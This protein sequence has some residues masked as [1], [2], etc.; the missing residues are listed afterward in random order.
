M[1]SRPSAGFYCAGAHSS[2]K[3]RATADRG[4]KANG[5]AA[6]ASVEVAALSNDEPH[7]LTHTCSE[8]ACS[9]AYEWCADEELATVHT[10]LGI[11]DGKDR[12]AS[13]KSKNHA[14]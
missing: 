11:S 4:P 2:R 12:H 7:A 5:D 8:R 3:P 14:R 6:G 9:A 1:K 13:R 10:S